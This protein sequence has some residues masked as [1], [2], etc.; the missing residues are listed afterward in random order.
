MVE[1]DDSL[2]AV[3]ISRAVSTSSFDRLLSALA[4]QHSRD[5]AEA[6]RGYHKLRDDNER[7]REEIRELRKASQLAL[8][9]ASATGSASI[10]VSSPCPEDWR[11][12]TNSHD[13]SAL[14]G[15]LDRLRDSGH[16]M[17]PRQPAPIPVNLK[18]ARA[19]EAGGT[20]PE[21]GGIGFRV[22]RL[23]QP[24]RRSSAA[25]VSEA[26]S[27]S[28]SIETGSGSDKG[29]NAISTVGRRRLGGMIKAVTKPLQRT[30]TVETSSPKQ[31]PTIKAATS[32]LSRESRDSSPNDSN[33]KTRKQEDD[34]ALLQQT[35]ERLEQDRR[36]RKREHFRAMF[37]VRGKKNHITAADLA[38]VLQ[39][40]GKVD[41]TLERASALL[42]DLGRMAEE[43][44]IHD[45]APS[46]PV[47][48]RAHKQ[49]VA[50]QTATG[51]TKISSDGSKDIVAI[52]D[53]P[54]ER[55]RVRFH[56]SPSNHRRHRQPHRTA[57]LA[58]LAFERA[59][60]GLF[61]TRSLSVSTGGL[62]ATLNFTVFVDM[63]LSPTLSHR[64]TDP[65]KA[66]EV[67]EVQDMLLVEDTEQVIAKVTHATTEM[68]NE[69]DSEAMWQDVLLWYLNIFVSVAVITS[70]ITY[71]LSLDWEPS[72][73]GWFLLQA[74]CT[75]VFV[76]ELVIKLWLLGAAT[77]FCQKGDRWWNWT[78]TSITCVSV[79]DLC[80]YALSSTTDTAT[81]ARISLVLR[82]LRLVRIVRLVKLLRLPLFHELGSM[83]TGLLI[84]LP[85][86]V[87]VCCLLVVVIFSAALFLR[88]AVGPRG[89]ECHKGCT[90]EC[91]DDNADEIA[92]LS[93]LPS[94]C[95]LHYL[96][97]EEYFGT[98][99]KSMFT[100][101]RCMIGD[102]TTRTGRALAAELSSGFGARFDLA[103]S[104]GM[105]AAIFG[106]FN[107]IT[108]LF[109]EST[110]SALKY[111]E[112]Q[113]KKARQ[114]ETHWVQQKLEILIERIALLQRG[115]R[116]R[117][118][119]ASLALS[120]D[121]LREVLED[122]VVRD[123][124][125]DIDV[126][127]DMDSSVYE[128]FEWD[129]SGKVGLSEF[130]TTIMKLRGDLQKTDMVATWV[131]LRSLSDRFQDFQLVLLANQRQMMT[132]QELL[133]FPNKKEEASTQS[134]SPSG[135]PSQIVPD[136]KAGQ[137]SASID[138]D[139]YS[140]E[141]MS[142]K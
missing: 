74:L 36:R 91:F 44:Q 12:P 100:V 108:A 126:N 129:A 10:S 121:D 22:P 138:P 4:E 134:P 53:K 139:G 92:M 73:D 122:K 106:L 29:P 109:V 76:T 25:T 115:T 6:Y 1:R 90:G 114:Y 3:P 47:S 39:K 66:I 43:L 79:F 64:M 13:I 141:E 125:H 78:D 9:V 5:V 23:L 110:L 46:A 120:E 65:L 128:M 127:V 24:A 105:V 131:A 124:L 49:A 89:D 69:G 31:P 28:E 102:C 60:S 14:G 2:L 70:L 16:D 11:S 87:W 113:R 140:S 27:G 55:E 95:K 117:N 21:T 103:Y 111:N 98:V 63:M 41:F 51:V 137:V 67:R 112:L 35:V 133:L 59:K 56:R 75:L 85:W 77:Y 118:W 136:P 20:K 101:F 107:V 94:T 7:L 52:E 8:T 54:L 18:A 62:A 71:G 45:V 97:G 32:K 26:S 37:G 83:L 142:V 132:N 48:P 82:T 119:A 58:S 33:E 50:F 19:W 123:V 38:R 99:G 135:R 15:E 57:S 42:H 80:I 34:N 68:S 96:Y 130:V 88:Q 30:K 72:W 116:A 93:D 86:L 84:G 17:V 61:R 104:L 40:R 81:A